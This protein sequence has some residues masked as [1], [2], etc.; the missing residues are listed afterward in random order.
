MRNPDTDVMVVSLNEREA[1]FLNWLADIS[2]NI[3]D[4]SLAPGDPR[5]HFTLGE[6]VPLLK[7]LDW[8]RKD[9]RD[10]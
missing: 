2:P 6:L 9:Y 4:E 1:R 8:D 5:V 3:D 7:K 10:A